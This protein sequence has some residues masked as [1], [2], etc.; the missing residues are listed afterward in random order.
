[1]RRVAGTTGRPA[2]GSLV[3]M[4]PL[5]L[6]PD[7]VAE[8]GAYRAAMDAIKADPAHAASFE[9]ARLE[10]HEALIAHHGAAANWLRR[11]AQANAHHEAP[12]DL[13]DLDD[14][15]PF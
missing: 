14:L 10:G 5:D 3:N 6:D 12:E 7:V 15:P 13:D 8:H 9:A 2:G 4:P 1:M 11:T